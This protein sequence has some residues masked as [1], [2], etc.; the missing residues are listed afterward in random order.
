MKNLITKALGIAGITAL[1]FLPLK[2]EGQ[3]VLT[4][5]YI[6]LDYSKLNKT[7]KDSV[8]L[9]LYKETDSI[10][11]ERLFLYKQS[12]FYHKEY[13]KNKSPR[14]LEIADSLEKDANFYKMLQSDWLKREAN[15][16]CNLG[17]ILEELK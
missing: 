7:E 8:C 5:Y 1:S 15:K 3:D 14:F 10:Q 11:T 16:L 4:G 17:L 12:I 6:G 2:S 13:Q 9:E